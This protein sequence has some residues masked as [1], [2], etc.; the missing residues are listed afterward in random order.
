MR[1]KDCSAEFMRRIDCLVKAHNGSRKEL[2]KA[3]THQ[4]CLKQ[5]QVY[6]WL[7][8]SD[9]NYFFRLTTIRIAGLA[10]SIYGCSFQVLL[11]RSSGPRVAHALS[12]NGD[13]LGLSRRTGEKSTLAFAPGAPISA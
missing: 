9:V 1:G 7:R 10:G 4:T 12:R 3:L 8:L 5:V 11:I 6:Q 13:L 2:V